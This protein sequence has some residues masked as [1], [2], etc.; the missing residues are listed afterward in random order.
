[1][2]LLK[3][4]AIA[5]TLATP[6]VLHAQTCNVANDPAAQGDTLLGLSGAWDATYVLGD[7]SMDGV[8]LPYPHIDEPNA[9]VFA[10][11]DGQLSA[12]QDD[13]NAPMVFAWNTAAPLEFA[14]ADVR[15]GIPRPV[16][17]TDA[18]AAAGTCAI[19]NATRAVGTTDGT[20]RGQTMDFTWRLI[21]IDANAM[22]LV[23]HVAG[24]LSG[25]PYASRRIVALSR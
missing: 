15:L 11:T 21:V 2:K 20:L 7:V 6:S 23:Q 16:E 18:L 17:I 3:L 8:V 4:L 9:I 1:M 22:Y 12:W 24:T 19:E 14:D 25:A 10:T 5:V 13:M